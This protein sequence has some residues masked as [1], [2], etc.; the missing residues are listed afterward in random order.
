MPR[1]PD[2]RRA[3]NRENARHST[4]PKSTEGKARSRQNALKHGLCAAAPAA[5]PNEDPAA[6]QARAD[7]WNSHYRPQSPAARH[8]V[9]QCVRATLLSD[10]VDRYHA[11]ELAKQVRSAVAGWDEWGRDE[12]AAG[13][14]LIETQPAEAVRRLKGLACGCQWLI[15]RWEGL[16]RALKANGR[17]TEGERD[18][19][20][21]LLGADPWV[22]NAHLS[23]SGYKVR[24]HNE[25]LQATPNTHELTWMLTPHRMPT[26]ARGAYTLQTLPDDDA[27][28][29]F[30]S[31]VVAERLVALSEES[32]RRD[33]LEG[34]DRAEAADRAL[35]L[36][37]EISARLFLRYH[38][39]ARSAFHRSYKALVQ[40]LER[41]E[42]EREG[43]SEAFSRNEPTGDVA[44]LDESRN[45]PTAA[46]PAP[47]E[48]S[49][50][51]P[52]DAA[53]E[54]P[55][56]EPNGAAVEASGD[57]PAGETGRSRKAHRG[58][59]ANEVL[60]IRWDAGEVPCATVGALEAESRD[61][62][63]AGV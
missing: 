14:R 59:K 51:E 4:G 57:V 1:T 40:T 15:D 36:H 50:N 23:L 63:G 56:N 26:E 42:A 49:P 39:E 7:E 22:N 28:R 58:R 44:P 29:A 32:A 53:S 13:V 25:L 9:D 34:L 45:E 62:V 20:I 16:G 31:Q 33:A 2:E 10:R 35:V 24:L 43:P 38:A 60:T 54:V 12:L 21:Q 6:V 46:G 5:L 30:L 19:A 18:R 48:I 17:W 27:C 8:L 3:I 47:A 61:L 11:A 52:N 37:D 55:P 41:D